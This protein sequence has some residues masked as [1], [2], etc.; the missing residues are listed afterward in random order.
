MDEIAKIILS[1]LP[2]LEGWISTAQVVVSALPAYVEEVV[3]TA[4]V[5]LT[6]RPY[7]GI[8]VWLYGLIGAGFLTWA[9]EVLVEGKPWI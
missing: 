1:A 5:V 4:T 6:A 2:F 3:S 8:P 9:W 7:F